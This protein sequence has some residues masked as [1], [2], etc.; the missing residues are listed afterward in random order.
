MTTFLLLSQRTQQA[1]TT[2]QR[3][4]SVFAHKSERPRSRS[5][6]SAH[7]A[8][9]SR[10]N[11]VQGRP[12]SR[13]HV[14]PQA[15]TRIGTRRERSSRESGH[16]A[17]AARETTLPRT[18][19]HSL[20]EHATIAIPGPAESASTSSAQPPPPKR[21]ATHA[22]RAEDRWARHPRCTTT[23]DMH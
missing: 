3:R 14:E 8:P 17:S 18:R 11:Y 9:R 21:S 22:R 2:L 20:A 23:Q 7:G 12:H 19:P 10:S 15:A 6:S 4:G 5:D 16:G 1:Q 13:A